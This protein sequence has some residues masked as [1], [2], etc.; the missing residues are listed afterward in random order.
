MRIY[1][2]ATFSWLQ[3]LLTTGKL[4]P[5]AAFAVTPALREYFVA[6]D[7]E[8]IAYQAYLDAARASLRMLAAGHEE[9]FPHRRVVLTFE[10][11][12]SRVSWGEDSSVTLTPDELSVD[13][14]A[15]IHIDV[16]RAE[17]DTAAAMAV[18]D[19][20]DLGDDDAEHLLANCEDHD[21]AW[22]DSAELAFVVELM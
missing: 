4:H 12:D 2:P 8:E 16:A 20:A 6:G 3:P 18:V 21:L 5:R 1:V 13:D 19:Q 11:P 22:Y 7:E 17:E 10:V 15:S 9:R 14:L